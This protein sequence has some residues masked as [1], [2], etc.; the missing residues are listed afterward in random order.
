MELLALAGLLLLLSNRSTTG[1]S[2]TGGG[3]PMQF[4]GA[5]GP[6]GRRR[7]GVPPSVDTSPGQDDP[8]DDGAPPRPTD[9]VGA[10]SGL[11]RHT[12]TV[13]AEVASAMAGRHVVAQPNALQSRHPP[14]PD[15]VPTRS[16]SAGLRPYA[17]R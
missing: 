14:D 8:A 10:L 5:L 3:I 13:S 17:P 1:S 16:R 6:V 4:F 2:T 7:A 15:P 9:Y 11:G 12:P